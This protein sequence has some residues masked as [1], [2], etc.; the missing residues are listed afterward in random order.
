[1]QSFARVANEKVVEII[2][3]PAG[4]DVAESFPFSI[5]ETLFPCDDNVR[6]GWAFVS[7]QFSED[8]PSPQDLAQAQAERLA[9]LKACCASAIVNGY[10]SEALG[11]SHRY[12]SGVTDQIN[13]MGSVTASLLP[14]LPADWTTPFW[15]C[16]TEGVWRWLPHSSLQIRQAGRDGKAHVVLCQSTLESLTAQVNAAESVDDVAAVVWP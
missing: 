14:E 5:V 12:P 10:A 1:M 4:L 9:L 7:G 6:E 2:S 11:A 8:Q 3:F 13:M 15:C 16:S